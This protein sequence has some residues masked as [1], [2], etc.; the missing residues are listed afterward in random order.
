MNIFSSLSLGN[1]RLNEANLSAMLGFLLAP[2][3]QHGFGDEFLKRFLSAI[4]KVRFS[5]FIASRLPPQAEVLYETAYTLTEVGRVVIDVEIRIYEH[6]FT[7]NEDFVPE[8]HRILIGSASREQLKNEYLAVM[9]ELDA[10]MDENLARPDLTVVF[11]TPPGQ[12]KDLDEE[13]KGIETLQE[14]KCRRLRWSIEGEENITFLLRGILKDESAAKI[15]PI[16]DYIRHTVKAFIQHVEE[17]EA[18]IELKS[19]GRRRL[20][21]DSDLVDEIVV[22]LGEYSYKL[23][24]Y[25]S[26][27]IRAFNA[28]TLLEV[29]PTIGVLRQIVKY[30]EGE[31]IKIFTVNSAGREKNTRSLGKDVIERLGRA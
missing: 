2:N 15:H 8:I 28:E 20:N 7:N 22:D 18:G 27:A 30:L 3:R 14:V 24:R 10:E 1:G 26:G 16:P 17:T 25:R 5:N 23:Q 12:H 19:S 4:D 11:L 6:S 9:Q 21:D 31:G 29:V 13:W